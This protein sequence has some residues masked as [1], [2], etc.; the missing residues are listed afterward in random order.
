MSCLL[1][2]ED[3]ILVTNEEHLPILEVD[4]NFTGTNLNADFHWLM[5]V[6][7]R[8]LVHD[9]CEQLFPQGNLY[10]LLFCLRLHVPGRMASL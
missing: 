7:N 6:E 10:I 4:E 1:Y 8:P 5:K 2:N 9:Y 3:K